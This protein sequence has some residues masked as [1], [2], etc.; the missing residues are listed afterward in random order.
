MEGL[1]QLVSA[2][3]CGPEG[4]GFE[5]HISPQKRKGVSRKR[6]TF[7]FLRRDIAK[8]F[9]SMQVLCT[10]RERGARKRFEICT[11][12]PRLGSESHISPQKKLH[13]ACKMEFFSY[14]RLAASSMHK[15]VICPSDVICASRV[16]SYKANIISLRNEVE[17]YHFCGAKISR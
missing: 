11:N 9:E 8:M 17:Q 6:N 2:S 7:S 12:A 14:I 13:L 15:C 4:R 3:G 10:C 1:A 16:G 5:S